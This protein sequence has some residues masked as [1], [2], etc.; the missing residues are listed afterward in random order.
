MQI[1]RT[2]RFARW[3]QLA[4]A[5]IATMVAV[6]LAATP[7]AEAATASST[8]TLLGQLP[9][10]TEHSAGY[11]RA[12]FPT[13]ID[14][15]KDGCNTRAEVLIAEATIKPDIGAKC[16]LSGGRWLS[17]YD[18]VVVTAA[19]NLDID[20]LVPLAE[21]WQSGAW[22]W[23]AATRTAYAN[24]LGYAADLVAVTAHANRAKGDREP[25]A[26]LPTAR[27]YD[28]SY[29]AQWVAV[30]WRW[31]L[32]V[33]PAEK[34]W[35]TKFL[36]ACRW[37]MIA[38]PPRPAI[39]NIAQPKIATF[40]TCTDMHKIYPHGVGKLGAKDSTTGT[41]DTRFLVSTAIYTANQALDRD[42]DGIACEA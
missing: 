12:L 7:A 16:A 40:A 32:S 20:H 15:D 11:L 29:V 6:S 23:S 1:A 25:S 19:A 13:W 14:A 34:A 35:L 17:P 18:H 27:S 3:A 41:P 33:D 28:C 8:K 39:V 24:D 21:A 42:K 31:R 38:T 4:A 36:A 9:V 10:A 26:Y 30:K 5:T 22:R 37:P 2:T